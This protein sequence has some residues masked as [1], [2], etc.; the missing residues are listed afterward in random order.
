M[1]S[2]PQIFQLSEMLVEKAKQTRA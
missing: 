2:G 1:E